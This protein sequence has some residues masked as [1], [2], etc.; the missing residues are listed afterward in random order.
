MSQLNFASMLTE[1]ERQCV[2]LILE[3]AGNKL[4]A[5]EMKISEETVKRHLSNI[6]DKVGC[7][8]RL[9]LALMYSANQNG[10]DIYMKAYE[11]D[12]CHKD[13]VIKLPNDKPTFYSL[14]IGDREHKGVACPACVPKVKISAAA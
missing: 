8:T 10:T 3:G 13:V 9:E 2:E 5:E 6:F 1:R 12:L 7:S 14:S 11:C 4:M